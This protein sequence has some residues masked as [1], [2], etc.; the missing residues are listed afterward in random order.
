MLDPSVSDNCSEATKLVF[1][2]QHVI[3][4]ESEKITNLPSNKVNPTIEKQA[5]NDI[6]ALLMV[7]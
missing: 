3:I 6:V 4:I 5:T 7:S 2:I 1:G